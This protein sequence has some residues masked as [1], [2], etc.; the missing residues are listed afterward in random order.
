MIPSALA[1]LAALLPASPA[2]S[3]YR[4]SLD[5]LRVDAP[6]VAAP[7]IDIDGRPDESGW[8]DAAVLTDFTQYDPAEGIPAT[9]RTETLVLVSDDAL[10]VAVRAFDDN[11]GG[12]RASIAPRDNVVRRD[13]Y[14]RVT[15]DTF[16]DRRRAY[17]FVV[18]PFGVQQDGVWAEGGGGRGRGRGFGPPVDYNPNFIWES[19]GRVEEWGYQVEFKVPFK[20]L[21]FPTAPVQAWGFQ[22]MRRIERYG[23]EASWAPISRNETNQLAQAGQLEGLRGLN[24]G[25]FLEMNPVLTG[26]RQGTADDTGLLI[27]DS[28]TGEFGLNAT[29]GLTSNLTLDATYNPDFSQVEADAGQIAVNERFALFFPEK[30]PF[31]LE[32]TDVFSL[33]Q[34]LVYTRSIANPIGGAKLTGKIGDVGVGYLGAYDDVSS[35]VS[36]EYARV[37]LLRARKDIGGSS[38]IGAV[39]TD[40]T[41]S[42]SVFN[43]LVGADARLVMGG[44]YTLT[45]LGAISSTR[46]D[47]DPGSAGGQ[48]WS[49]RFDKTGREFSWNAGIEDSSHDFDAASGFLRRIGDTQLNSRVAWNWYGEPGST[50]E[51]VGPSLQF[52]G[53][54]DHDTFWRGG[55]WEEAELE[56]GGSLSFRGNTSIFANYQR[57]GFR[58]PDVE[59]EGL[60]V[61]PPAGQTAGT[62]FVPEANAF[63]GMDQLRVFLFMGRWQSVRGR[64][65]GTWSETPIF[66]SGSPVEAATSFSSE[67][68]VSI[69]PTPSLSMELNFRYSALFRQSTGERY[70]TAQIARVRTQ[71]QL[72][73]ALFV[74]GIAERSTS[75]VASVLTPAGQQLERC[76]STGSCSALV[77]G[78]GRGLYLEGLLSFEPS[79]GTVFFLGY[80]RSLDDEVLPQVRDLRTRAD[81]LFVKLSYRYRF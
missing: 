15:L 4:G 8:S 58:F 5:E 57:S 12:I 7:N 81:G 25:L 11:P 72:T 44:R 38:S 78:D 27:H 39:M 6:F 69:Y 59:Y 64:V 60:R 61:A 48:L 41:E 33:P 79:P 66:V 53:V 36:S 54:W 70:S 17:V 76:D 26:S 21:K 67:N 1:L 74:R 19:E 63:R 37:N 55:A 80:S 43:R 22:V 16:N 73:K 29:Y 31:F 9:Q 68:N 62:P 14:I 30:R 3:L 75:E 51:R 2:D 71:Y 20:S 50:L 10:Y 34:Q 35:G 28:P 45:L 56:L 77:G 32:G 49:A 18:N 47:A 42:S 46:E 24:A 23:Y 65:G 40:R 52:R 13:D